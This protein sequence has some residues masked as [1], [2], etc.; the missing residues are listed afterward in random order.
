MGWW[1]AEDLSGHLAGEVMWCR[2]IN[3]AGAGYQDSVSG[4]IIFCHS[5]TCHALSAH[6]ICL[7]DGGVS[8]EHSYITRRPHWQMY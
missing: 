8:E 1:R 4:C 7:P 6:L 2:Q 3:R 5:S